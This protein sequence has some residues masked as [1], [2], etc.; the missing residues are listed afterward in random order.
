MLQQAMDRNATDDHIWFSFVL[1]G[2]LSCLAV[3]MVFAF[4]RFSISNILLVKVVIA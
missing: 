1:V 2:L 3:S 4:I